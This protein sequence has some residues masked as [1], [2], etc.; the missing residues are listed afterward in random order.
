MSTPAR[1][2]V[3]ARHAGPGPW[4]EWALLLLSAASGAA[5]AFVFICVGQV[6]AGVMTG[7]LVLLGASAAG[8]GE[9]GVALRVITALVAYA[10][11]VGCGAWMSERLRCSLPVMLLVEVVL[12]TAAAVLWALGLI[13]SDGD[14]LGLLVLIAVAMGVQGRIRA[15]P[16]NYFTGTLTALVGRAAL[17]SWERGD[18]WVA[19]RLIAVVAGAG[20]TALAVRLWPDAAALV[21]AVPAAG[22]LL[23]ETVRR[24]AS[25][26]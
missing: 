4:G 22:A 26:V 18:R 23:I 13:A 10:V 21:A 7:N 14:R 12:L 6:F 9:Q 15:T 1:R 20:V 24:R 8:A 25:A 16:T 17:R 3:P 5:D 11:G 19:G 2:S